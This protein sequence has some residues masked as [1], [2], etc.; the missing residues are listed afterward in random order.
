MPKGIFGFQKGDLN[1]SRTP[2]GRAR[3]KAWRKTVKLSK[4][5]KRKIGISMRRALKNPALREKWSKVKIGQKVAQSTKEKISKAHATRPK[6]ISALVHKLDSIYAR[7]IRFRAR[8]HQGYV[9]CFTCLRRLSVAEIDCGHYV[10]R[11]HHST[12]FFEENTHPQCRYCN[13]YR[14][15]EKDLYALH[16]KK[17]YGEGILEKLNRMRKEIKQFSHDELLGMIKDYKEK[18]KSVEKDTAHE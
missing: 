14:D 18:L 10:S 1:P 16:L 13:R 12:R 15:G 7:Y 17:K 6:T 11:S 9:E 5:T 4:S 2:E 3:I 8:D